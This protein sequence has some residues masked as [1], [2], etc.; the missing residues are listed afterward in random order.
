MGVLPIAECCSKHYCKKATI[1][2]PILPL[3]IHIIDGKCDFAYAQHAWGELIFQ[4]GSKYFTPY[5]KY[6]CR[7]ERI[8]RGSKYN[9]T[10]P[11]RP[12]RL[13]PAWALACSLLE[14]P[15]RLLHTQQLSLV[16]RIDYTGMG[17]YSCIV[18]IV[19]AFA[20]TQEIM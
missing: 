8:L 4:E 1:R 13:F 12:L 17:L 15:C 6:L 16:P 14:A 7:P 19:A 10:A 11:L 5:L 2:S 18:V 3:D 9:V 20:W